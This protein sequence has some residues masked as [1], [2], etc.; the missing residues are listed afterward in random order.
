[1]RSEQ[2]SRAQRASDTRPRCRLPC[3]A[4]NKDPRTHLR[5]CSNARSHTEFSK[6][7]PRN[8]ARK[9]PDVC[10]VAC[11]SAFSST[12]A[13]TRDNSRNWHNDRTNFQD[14]GEWD[15]SLHPIA[16]RRLPSPNCILR[17]FSFWQR[18]ARRAIRRIA[19]CRAGSLFATCYSD[20]FFLS[21]S[22]SLS[23]SLSLSL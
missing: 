19:Q 7:I 3:S 12:L 9:N 17:A 4:S 21:L 13:S 14:N 10:D 1:M 22:P 18:R 16:R 6:S 8:R 20:F 5:G 11:A 2:K 23:L 15:P